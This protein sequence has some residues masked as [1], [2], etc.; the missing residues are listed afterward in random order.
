MPKEKE[1][2]FKFCDQEYQGVLKHLSVRWLY[3]E[4]CIS[5]ETLKFTSLKS[6]FLSEGFSNERFQRLQ[7]KF[8]NPPLEPALLFLSSELPL[9]TNFNQFLQ[10]EGP[11]IQM[12]KPAIEGLVGKVA[13][14]I[15]LPAKVGEISCISKT[16]LNDPENFMDTQNI[17]LGILTTTTKKKKM[18][19]KLLDQGD[20]SQ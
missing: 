16:D 3:L 2:Y 7:E 20:I 4:R 9:F 13:K 5:R 11:T 17:Y 14:R 1:N 12:L 6:Y 18:L 10:R 15:M 8:T 19:K